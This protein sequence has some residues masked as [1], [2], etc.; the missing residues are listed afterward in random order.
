MIWTRVISC[1]GGDKRLIG[2]AQNESGEGG[3]GT[4]D[5]RRARGLQGEFL[6]D[7]GQGMLQA[8]DNDL[9]KGRKALQ[10]QLWGPRPK[11][12]EG[13]GPVQAGGAR[14]GGGREHAWILGSRCGA[15]R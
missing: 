15:Q 10:R 9:G 12:Q 4:A 6:K 2:A 1:N 5:A 7:G 13:W 3:G 8:D 11:E 14:Y